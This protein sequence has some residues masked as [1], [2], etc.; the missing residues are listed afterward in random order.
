MNHSWP[1]NVRELE[2]LIERVVITTDRGVL[3]TKDFCRFLT[4]PQEVPNLFAV[5]KAA[6]QK[7]ERARILQALR[8]VGGSKQKAAHLLKI[9][10]AT[11]YNK[12]RQYEFLA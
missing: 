3:T 5:G 12:L 9:S 10:R 8:A 11:L 1:G 6:L 7:A 4:L 2:N